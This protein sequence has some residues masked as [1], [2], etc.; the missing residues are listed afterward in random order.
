MLYAKL[1]RRKRATIRICDQSLDT[2]AS[3][4]WTP[5]KF[6]STRSY[7]QNMVTALGTTRMRWGLRPP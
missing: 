3:S 7:T 6:L 2:A 1:E 4:F 5:L